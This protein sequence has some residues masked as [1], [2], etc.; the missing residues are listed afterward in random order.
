MLYEFIFYLIYHFQVIWKSVY[1]KS[2]RTVHLTSKI[3]HCHFSG[4]ILSANSLNYNVL[5]INSKHFEFPNLLF[6]SCELF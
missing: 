5:I 6:G 2:V 1:A 3:T 4:N